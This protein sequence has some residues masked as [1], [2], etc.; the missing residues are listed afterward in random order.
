MKRHH[1][2]MICA[3]LALTGS[4]TPAVADSHSN[5]KDNFSFS[6]NLDIYTRLLKELTT[7]YVDTFDLSKTVNNGIN[8]ML[9]R[10]DP[11][12]EYITEAESKD[13]YTHTTGEYGGIGSYIMQ[14]DGGVFISEPYEGQPAQ[15]AG[16]RA[17]DK[18]IMIDNDTVTGW[19]SSQVSERLK[20]QPN[21]PLK[22]TL[23]RPGTSNDTIVINLTRKKIQMNAVPYYGIVGDSIGYIYLNSF[24]DK[25]AEEVK[26]ALLDL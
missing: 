4:I 14:R 22:L 1:I 26:E 7:Y 6:Q 10:L 13:F 19:S 24:T 20:G 25:A 12:T 3:A 21:T 8:Y 9:N 15:L 23:L 11:Y 5:D 2:F 17:G 18:I 16:V